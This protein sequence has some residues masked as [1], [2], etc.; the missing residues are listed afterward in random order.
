[1]LAS[2]H[3]ILP[4]PDLGKTLPDGDK[5]GYAHKESETILPAVCDSIFSLPSHS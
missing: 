1:M 3:L 2:S 4:E 5:E